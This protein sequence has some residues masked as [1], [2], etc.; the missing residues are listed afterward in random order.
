VVLIYIGVKMLLL[1]WKIHIPIGLSLGVVV[2]IILTS[3]LASLIATALEK[4]RPPSAGS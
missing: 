2:G 1:I 4:R 3:V